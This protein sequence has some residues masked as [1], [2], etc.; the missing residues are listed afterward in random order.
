MMKPLEFLGFLAS[1]FS[2]FIRPDGQSGSNH[3]MA[4]HP[5]TFKP[6]SLL[7]QFFCHN[8]L[9]GAKKV[10]AFTGCLQRLPAEFMAECSAWFGNPPCHLPSPAA[11]TSAIF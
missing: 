7:L 11:R 8:V 10:V 5:A 2:I 3:P 9:A 6:A 1:Q 4:L